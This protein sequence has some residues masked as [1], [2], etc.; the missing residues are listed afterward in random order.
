MPD[1]PVPNANTPPSQDEQADLI[2]NLA[3]R[4]ELNEWER[5]N[6][7]RARQWALADRQLARSNAVSEDYIRELHRRMFD[8]TWKWAGAYRKT[9]KNLG[10]PV[11]Q[12]LEKLGQLLG[13]A[14]YWLENKI[15]VVDECAVRFHY[16]L[17][18]IHLFPN[19]NGRHARLIG[20][21]VA[22]KN[23]RPAFSWGS[24]DLIAPGEAREAYLQALRA[25][26][27]GDLRPLLIFARS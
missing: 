8:Q 14:A 18:V 25:A 1:L 7:L 6:I 23:A 11:H 9:E 12:I 17:V 10:V 20:D 2:P 15:Y 27:H 22:V 16:E 3:T 21:V 19:G 4:E 5:D 13:N 26:D 24:R